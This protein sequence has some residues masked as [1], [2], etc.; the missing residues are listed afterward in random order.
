MARLPFIK[1]LRVGRILMEGLSRKQQCKIKRSIIIETNKHE[2][3]NCLAHEYHYNF[4]PKVLS[5]I[6]SKNS[7]PFHCFS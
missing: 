6:D 5:I 4:C 2:M 3:C 7:P 1:S